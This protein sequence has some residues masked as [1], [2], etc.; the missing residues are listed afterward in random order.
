[1]G[2]GG[3]GGGGGFFFL[4]MIIKRKMDELTVDYELSIELYSS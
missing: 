3:G 1:V 2:E 4:E